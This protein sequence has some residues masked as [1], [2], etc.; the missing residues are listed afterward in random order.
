LRAS[1]G[2]NARQEQRVDRAEADAARRI[3]P[4]HENPSEPL[5]E[6]RSRMPP[7]SAATALA[8]RG[9]LD[10]REHGGTLGVSGLIFPV[11][12]PAFSTGCGKRK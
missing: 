6:R 7:P 4:R 5:C 11:P 10:G 8:A 9:V 12:L 2:A 1:A 3:T